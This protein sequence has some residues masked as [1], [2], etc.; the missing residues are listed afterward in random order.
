[1]LRH[2]WYRLTLYP[3]LAMGLMALSPLAPAAETSI[4][5]TVQPKDE[6]IKMAEASFHSPEDWKEVVR[7]N[8]LKNPDAIHPGQV[9]RIPLRLFKTQASVGRLISVSGEVQLSGQEAQAGARVP[10]GSQLKTSADSSVMLQLDDGSRITLMPNSQATLVTSQSLG[11]GGTSDKTSASWFTGL[12]RL[13]QGAVTVMATKLAR[14]NTPLKI[15]TPTSVMGVRG[16]EF[17]VTYD[18]PSTQNSRTEVLEGL[19]RADNPTQGSG[20]D[21]PK[22]TGTVIN[23]G[24]KEIKVVKLLKAPTLSKTSIA[25][26]KPQALWQ[27]PALDGAKNYR[28]QI[29]GHKDFSNIVRNA[30][31]SNGKAD[32]SDLPN[33]L[34]H[35]RLR[36]IDTHGLEGFDATGTLQVLQTAGPDQAMRQWTVDGNQLDVQNG[37]HVLTF[38]QRGLDRSHAILAVVKINRPPYVRIA[39]ALTQPR[40]GTI[41]LNLGPLKPGEKYQLNLT[42]AQ[43]DGATLTPSNYQF[44]GQPDGAHVKAPLYP[45]SSRE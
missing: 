17:R 28:V 1:M 4:A 35:L 23:P 29:S 13:S 15:E 20:A 9:L 33:G 3:W 7:I 14:R 22:G 25:V 41:T 27:I 8:R 12:L 24:M 32:F 44:E 11:V 19:V 21:L 30:L 16:T 40:D 39:K 18:D 37:Q 42:I 31:V 6:L 43:I 10:E 26:T 36:A 34:W 2:I 45:L 5:Y 38:E